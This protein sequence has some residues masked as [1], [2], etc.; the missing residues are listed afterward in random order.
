MLTKALLQRVAPWDELEAQA[1][2]DHRE[3]SAGNLGRS[4]ELVGD[5][6]AGSRWLPGQAAL[7]GQRLADTTD[8]GALQL[9]NQVAGCPKRKR[10][11]V[12]L[13]VLTG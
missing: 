6:F 2:V 13:L 1:M 8:V 5:L 11:A 3:P 7:G 9:G 12:A 4:D 10:C